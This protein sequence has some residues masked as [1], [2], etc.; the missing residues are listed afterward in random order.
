MGELK[1][2]GERIEFST[3]MVRD[4]ESNKPRFDLMHPRGVPYSEQMLTRVATHLSR[5]AQKYEERNW[6]KA[7]TQAELDRTISSLTRHLEQYITGETD[8]DHAAAV[9]TNV[10]FAETIRYKMRTTQSDVF[11]YGA[12]ITVDES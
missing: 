7:N 12:N 8:E 11:Y 4:T 1:D 5:G 9:I 2:S 3:G 6:E 10:L